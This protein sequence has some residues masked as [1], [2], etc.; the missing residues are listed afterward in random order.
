MYYLWD[1]YLC[2]YSY[3]LGIANFNYLGKKL[4]I[5]NNTELQVWVNLLHTNKP[6][7]AN[8]E[9]QYEWIYY[10]QISHSGPT[11]SYRYEWIYYTQI[12]HSG[13]ILIRIGNNIP[14]C[15]NQN[16]FILFLSFNDHGLA[17]YF[18][19]VHLTSHAGR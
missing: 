16:F 10:T 3:K 14:I 7:R 9:L 13:P 6:F 15:I 4:T 11:L 5:H 1:F 12:S 17:F 19:S 18:S 2:Y 8:T